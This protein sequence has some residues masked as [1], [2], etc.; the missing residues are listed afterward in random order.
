MPRDLRI[1]AED[2]TRGAHLSQRA[3]KVT[4]YSFFKELA[5][6]PP[7]FSQ[8]PVRNSMKTR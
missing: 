4:L 6:R 7:A 2:R 5:R 8:S 1:A 3:A